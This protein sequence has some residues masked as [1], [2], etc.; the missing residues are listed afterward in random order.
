MHAGRHGVRASGIMMLCILSTP[1]CKT[2]DY[3]LPSLAAVMGLAVEGR[4]FV[5]RVGNLRTDD[6][7]FDEIT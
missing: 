4:P 2:S 3:S 5:A 7:I 1:F 6:K